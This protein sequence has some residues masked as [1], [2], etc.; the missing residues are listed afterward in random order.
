MAPAYLI[1]KLHD[2]D[3]LMMFDMCCDLEVAKY[4][5]MDLMCSDADSEASWWKIIPC[6][7][8]PN[9]DS[10]YYDAIVHIDWENTNRIR[11]MGMYREDAAPAGLYD[12][13]MYV[14]ERVHLIV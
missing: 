4:K 11:F 5:L 1:V 8:D 2:G 7:I 10:G 9:F 6:D 14:S 3:I 12:D 13:Y